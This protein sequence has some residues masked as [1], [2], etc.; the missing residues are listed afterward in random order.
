M[1][2]LSR[3]LL[4]AAR[5][6]LAPDPAIAARVRARVAAAVNAPVAT[7]ATPAKAGAATGLVKIGAVALVALGVVA[8][9]VISRSDAPAA[10]PTVGAP[11][12]DEELSTP[13]VS[14]AEHVVVPAK[15]ALAPAPALQPEAEPEVTLAREVELVDRAMLALRGD[16]PSDA[17]AAI[18]LYHSETRGRG[19]LAEDAAAISIEAHCALHDDVK[20]QLVA[21][22]RAYPSSAQRERLRAACE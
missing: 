1:T 16:R 18:A 15:P 12:T 5:E 11:S 4:A 10:A 20:A 7:V 3:N 19:Q 6:G 13:R 9:V 17:I 8:A 14:A 2:E 21:F 22:D